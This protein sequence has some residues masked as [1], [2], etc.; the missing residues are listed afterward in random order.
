M[1]EV[2][3]LDDCAPPPPP[4]P[5]YDNDGVEDTVDLDDENDGVPDLKEYCN[6]DGG[7]FA[8]LPG[9]LDPNMDMDS[10]GVPNF[11]DADDPAV[12]NPCQDSDN[13]GICDAVATVY[14]TDGDNVPD[15]LD[16]DSDNDGITDLTEANH[17]QPDTDGDGIIDSLAGDFG[18][19]GLFNAIATDPDDFAATETL[20][21]MGLG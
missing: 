15:H 2:D 16:A 13:N 1:V 7:G 4:G 6:A 18:L 21:S 8:C 12:N 20:Y 5:D 11:L 14:D 17:G 19:N 10:D 3:I 9:G